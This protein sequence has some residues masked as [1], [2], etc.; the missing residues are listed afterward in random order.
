MSLR[1]ITVFFTVALQ[2]VLNW[3]SFGPQTFSLL[4]RLFCLFVDCWKSMQILWNSQPLF[5]HCCYGNVF[6]DL[7][8]VLHSGLAD[9]CSSLRSPFSIV[10]ATQ[11]E[12]ASCSSGWPQTP[13]LGRI[14][15][16]ELLIFQSPPMRGIDIK[17][18]QTKNKTL[19]SW[20]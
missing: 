9:F 5:F 11:R 7:S 8:V 20:I 4:T 12:A 15:D 2:Y 6:S 13:C 10:S 17:L 16:F 18:K 3:G 14:G 19:I 1:I